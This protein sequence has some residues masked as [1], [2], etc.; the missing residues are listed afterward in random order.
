MNRH[1]FFIIALICSPAV[2]A[3][4]LIYKRV[5]DRELL[6]HIEKP[7][8]WKATDQRPAIVFFFGGG[9]VGGSVEQFHPQSEYFA[10]RGVVGIRVEYRTI[11]KGDKGPPLVCCGD[12]KS[13]MRYVRGHAAELGVDPTRIAAAG[14]SAGG[15][16]A[17]FTAMVAGLDGPAEEAKISCKPD[18]L[19][20]FNPVFNNGPGEWGHER[21]G[22]RFREFSPAHNIRKTAPPTCVFLGDSDNLIGV[23]VL[24]EFEA[25]MK[26]A[27]VRCD[28]HVYPGAGHGF[29]NKDPHKSQTLA[30]ADKFL[31][32]LGWLK[33]T[34]A[35]KPNIVIFLTDDLGKLDCSPYGARDI[36]TPNMQRLAELGMTFDGAYV[37]SPSC[38]PSRAALLTG[39]M[40]ARNGAE[41]NHAIARGDVRKWP[42]YFHAPGYE[43]AAFGK[44]AHY[45]HTANYDFDR[46]S[47]DTFHDHAGIAKAVEFL[48]DRPRDG[49]KPLCLFVGS[50]WP[51]V[52]WPEKGD[53]DPAKLTLPA[54]SVDTPA[55]REWRARYAAAVTKADD[56]LGTILNA[57]REHLPADTV[58]V[59]SSDHGAQWPFAKW[60]LYER[61]VAVPLIVAWPGVVKPDTRSAALVQWIDFLPTFHA[62][63]GGG[64]LQGI[65]GRSF[66]PVLRGEK[67]TH[68]ERIFTTHSADGNMNVYPI[69]AVREGQWKYIRNLHPEFTF[70]T[71]IDADT[72]RLAQRDFFASWLDAAKNDKTA[73]ATVQ[74]YHQRPAE[75]LYDITADAH[76]Q[77]NLAPLPEHAERLATMRKALDDWMHEQGDTQKVYGEPRPL[78]GFPAAQVVK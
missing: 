54:G 20:L 24:R 56:D 4:S 14:G 7:V 38:A 30:E 23:P 32:S 3:E 31:V 61:G 41:Q 33:D 15:H 10:G 57:T 68:R 59:F 28:A 17:A 25:K 35:R 77:K 39:M 55:T 53:Y 1:Y 8:D 46:Y 50:N 21:V 22:E 64:E 62:A 12:A 49:A 29:F 40:P 51:H 47:N 13:A 70:T 43:V 44:V 6:L 58:F 16:L 11:A 9:W 27:G 36:R 75:E 42:T 67:E 18:A 60:N 73:A 66:L 5:G 34:V 72:G 45:K 26:A 52:P 69:R 63:A 2:S 19:I 65:D 71:H 78:K 37:A 76:E 48:K 74:R